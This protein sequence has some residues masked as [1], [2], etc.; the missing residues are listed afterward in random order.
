[1]NNAKKANRL[2]LLTKR[3]ALIPLLCPIYLH[4]RR[5]FKASVSK[6]LRTINVT[7]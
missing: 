5:R 2:I 6:S 4:L 7:I 1:M 3:K